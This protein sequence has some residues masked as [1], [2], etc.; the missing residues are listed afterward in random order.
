LFAFAL[1][2]AH[3]FVPAACACLCSYRS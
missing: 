3:V 2:L 1:L